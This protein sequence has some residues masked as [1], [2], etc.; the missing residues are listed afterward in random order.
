MNEIMNVFDKKEVQI[1][2]AAVLS[3]VSPSLSSLSLLIL[4]QSHL[5]LSVIL[6]QSHPFP[7]SSSPAVGDQIPLIS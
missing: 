6:T 3:L 4:T 1:R 7:L 2:L 5:F